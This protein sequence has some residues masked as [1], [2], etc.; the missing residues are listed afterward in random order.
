ME[1]VCQE[2]ERER[3][4]LLLDPVFLRTSGGKIFATSRK[5]RL[6]RFAAADGYV[7]IASSALVNRRVVRHVEL[8]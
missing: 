7:K 6:A 2:R 4:Y 8:R 5:N 1:D 3:K